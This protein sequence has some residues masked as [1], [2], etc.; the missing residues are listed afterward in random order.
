M[1]RISGAQVHPTRL[2]HAPLRC[3]FTEVHYDQIPIAIPG[4]APGD[5]VLERLVV[6]SASPLAEPPQATV[7][8][9]G[10][11]DSSEQLQESNLLILG[12]GFDVLVMPAQDLQDLAG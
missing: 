11:M 1:H 7:W 8:V 5:E 6:R 12:E 2:M 10:F 4:P 9:R 3:G